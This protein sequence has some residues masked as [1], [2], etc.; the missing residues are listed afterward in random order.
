MISFVSLIVSGR[1]VR[2]DHSVFSKGSRTI[3]GGSDSERA[4][5]VSTILRTN[6]VGPNRFCI[7]S[8]S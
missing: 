4:R 2:A 1:L 5:M 3:I 8:S 6:L 7:C